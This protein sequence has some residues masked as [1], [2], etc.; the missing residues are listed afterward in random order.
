MTV[1]VILNPDQKFPFEQDMMGQSSSAT[2]LNLE[3]VFKL[4]LKRTKSTS[5]S[6]KYLSLQP[7]QYQCLRSLLFKHLNYDAVLCI[8]IEKTSELLEQNFYPLHVSRA[9]ALEQSDK[10]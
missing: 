6:L 5:F 7:M 1:F 3:S 2:A 9:T 8:N 4:Q 10:H